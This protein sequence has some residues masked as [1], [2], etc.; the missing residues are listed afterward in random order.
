M[1]LNGLGDDDDTVVQPDIVVVCDES[2]LDD[3]G[4]NGAPD[5]VIEIL[6]PSSSGYDRVIKF[7]LYW[8]A[9]VR[10]YWIVD[11]ADKC[12][13]QFVL[14]NGEYVGRV[15]GESDSVPVSVLEGCV[16]SLEE[17]FAE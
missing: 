16:I 12:I 6:S 2:K 4:C 11:T 14:K 5:L 7:N 3:K 17:V 9:G 8:R 13:Q 1:R 15:F 10:E